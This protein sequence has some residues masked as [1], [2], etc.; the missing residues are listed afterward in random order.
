MPPHAGVTSALQKKKKKKESGLFVL[1]IFTIFTVT[2][3]KPLTWTHSLGGWFCLFSRCIG[4]QSPTTILASLSNTQ[5]K[6]TW[7]ILFIF[8]LHWLSES[9]LCSSLFVRHSIQVKV[10]GFVFYTCCTWFS[11]SQIQFNI[12]IFVPTIKAKLAETSMVFGNFF[13][14]LNFRLA[15]QDVF[16][17]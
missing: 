3:A 2:A 10:P 1:S 14:L 13:G 8:T 6:C 15:N 16:R 7:L 5:F 12:H 17:G 4:F 11:G 9:N